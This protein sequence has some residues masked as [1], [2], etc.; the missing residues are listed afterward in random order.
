VNGK[1]NSGGN[2]EDIMSADFMADKKRDVQKFNNLKEII[3]SDLHSL[4]RE[5]ISFFEETKLIASLNLIL[6]IF[7]FFKKIIYKNY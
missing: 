5:N 7:F 3:C 4:N 1:I 2:F 6:V